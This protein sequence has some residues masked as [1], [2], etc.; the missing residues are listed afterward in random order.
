MRQIQSWNQLL[1]EFQLSC[2]TYLGYFEAIYPPIVICRMAPKVT[3]DRFFVQ[4]IRTKNAKNYFLIAHSTVPIQNFSLNAD[5][6]V[7]SFRSFQLRRIFRRL[8]RIFV[9]LFFYG[10]FRKFSLPLEPILFQLKLKNR[11][12]EAQGLCTFMNKHP[13]DPS[14]DILSSKF[15]F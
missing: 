2:H 14:K 9:Y 8:R 3:H 6:H 10:C 5:H 4:R 15:N 11:F 12:I 7:S 1:G 13:T